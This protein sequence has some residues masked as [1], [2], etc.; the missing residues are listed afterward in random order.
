MRNYKAY[1]HLL[2]RIWTSDREALR[3]ARLGYST[4]MKHCVF[5]EAETEHVKTRG[6]GKA[7][8]GRLNEPNTCVQCDGA[9]HTC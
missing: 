7:I 6:S 4:K 2:Q 8:N 9:L 5:C 3:L 1:A